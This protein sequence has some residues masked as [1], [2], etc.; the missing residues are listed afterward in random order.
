M[1]SSTRVYMF[2]LAVAD[3]CVCVCGIVLTTTW[4]EA[5]TG[6]IIVRV[7]IN[8]AI[9]SSA[10]RLVCHWAGCSSHVAIHIQ[11][12]SAQSEEY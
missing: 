7:F 3:S 1:T 2:A 8:L 12:G 10:F 6:L 9:L 4:I 11:H 5:I